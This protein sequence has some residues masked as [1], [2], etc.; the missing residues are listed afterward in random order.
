ME[1]K[2]EL[3]TIEIPRMNFNM[4]GAIAWIKHKGYKAEKVDITPNYYRFRQRPPGKN[5]HYYSVKLNNGIV[6]V[7]ME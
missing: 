7:F 5:R 4:S 3:Q 2:G 6:L 1:K